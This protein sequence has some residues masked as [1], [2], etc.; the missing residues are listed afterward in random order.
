MLQSYRKK[1]LG[2]SGIEDLIKKAG[3]QSALARKMGRSQ[4]TVWRWKEQGYLPRKHIARAAELYG[5]APSTLVD[6]RVLQYCRS[7]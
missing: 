2:M 5:V 3:G 1:E 4:A 6:P 7:A